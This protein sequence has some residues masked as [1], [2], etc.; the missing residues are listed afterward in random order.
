MPKKEPI[1]LVLFDV[2]RHFFF[3]ALDTLHYCF[4]EPPQENLR[5]ETGDIYGTEEANA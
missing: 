2:E 1:K 3:R 5:L 4:H